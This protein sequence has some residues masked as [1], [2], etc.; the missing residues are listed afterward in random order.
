MENIDNIKKSLNDLVEFKEVSFITKIQEKTLGKWSRE[1]RIKRIGKKNNFYI[2]KEDVINLIDSNINFINGN[3][4]ISRVSK[5]LNI[6]LST[7]RYW[8][9]SK[10]INAFKDFAGRWVVK[11]DDIIKIKSMFEQIKL[12]DTILLGVNRYYSLIKLVND[13][14]NKRCN[15]DK[16]EYNKLFERY[17]KSFYRIIVLKDN[18]FNYRLFGYNKK[19]IFIDETVYYIFMNMIKI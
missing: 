12:E 14:I 6:P 3:I 4:R 9:E 17:Y 1:G 11:N 16:E 7:I 2:L 8:C 13:Y 5:D 15:V 10:K 19:R 18:N